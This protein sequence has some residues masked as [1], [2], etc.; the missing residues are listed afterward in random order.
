MSTVFIANKSKYLSMMKNTMLDSTLMRFSYADLYDNVIDDNDYSFSAAKL[1]QFELEL[2][3]SS[4][5]N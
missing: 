1:K 5:S 4:R 2:A 3:E